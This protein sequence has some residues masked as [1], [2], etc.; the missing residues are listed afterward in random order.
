VTEEEQERAR[1]R[2]DPLLK[3]LRRE[4]GTLS[5]EDDSALVYVPDEDAGQ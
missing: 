5:P 1:M 3:A 4:T 2:V